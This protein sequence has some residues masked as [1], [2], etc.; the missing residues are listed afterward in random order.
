MTFAALVAGGL[1]TLAGL[2]VSVL[3]AVIAWA[4]MGRSQRTPDPLA[5]VLCPCCRRTH[6]PFPSDRYRTTLDARSTR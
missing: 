4:S 5:S 6:S 1:I 2:A 3:C